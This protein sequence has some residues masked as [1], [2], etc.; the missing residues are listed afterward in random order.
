MKKIYILAAIFA[1]LTGVAAY[2]FAS[3]LEKKATVIT[4][5]GQ[6]VVA[7]VPIGENMVITSD[8]VAL[9]ETA[10]EWVAP[11]AITSLNDAVGKISRYYLPLGQQLS[12]EQLSDITS[13]SQ[14]GQLSYVVEEGMRAITLSIDEA[15]GVGGYISKSDFVDIMCA[16]TIYDEEEAPDGT[17][18][19]TKTYA[20]GLLIERVRVLELGPLSANISGQQVTGYGLITL[21]LNAD[22]ALALHY[23]ITS[24]A[25]IYFTLRNPSDTSAGPSELFIPLPVLGR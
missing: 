25:H 14:G 7:A 1:V 18:E 3:A 12:H 9:K 20:S 6:V 16:Y 24:G 8:M 2:F 10:L 23:A 13:G 11:N 21:S 22:D 5:M 15:A 4:P 17:K 19:I